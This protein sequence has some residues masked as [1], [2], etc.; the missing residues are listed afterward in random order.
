[1][2]QGEPD[3]RQ[4]QGLGE[5]RRWEISTEICYSL[6]LGVSRQFLM[7]QRRLVLFCLSVFYHQGRFKTDLSA[8]VPTRTL[9]GPKVVRNYAFS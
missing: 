9:S 2:T 5:G 1:M 4:A 8:S 6:D 3:K 7:T